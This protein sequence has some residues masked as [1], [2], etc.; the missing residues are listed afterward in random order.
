MSGPAGCLP[1]IQI[2]PT[3]QCNLRCLHCYSD[4]GPEVSAELDAELV[5]RVLSDAA[6]LGYRVCSVS[7]GEPLLYEPLAKVLRGAHEHGLITTVTTNGMLLDGRRL[8][9][10]EPDT[11]LVA[12]SLDG[13]PES[14]AEMRVSPSAFRTM[15]TRLSGLRASGIPFGFIFT[16]TFHNVNELD[17]VAQFAIEQG[18]KLLQIHPLEPVGRAATTLDGS[19]PDPQESGCALI[20]AVRLRDLYGDQIQIQFDL[21]TLPAVRDHPEKIYACP[22]ELCGDYTI[23]DVIAP[24][25]LETSGVVAPLQYGFPRPWCFGNVNQAPLRDLAVAWIGSK[26]AAFGA[27]CRDVRD[28]MLRH[29]ESPVVNWYVQVH[30]A[31]ALVGPGAFS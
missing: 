10:L 5:L 2:H 14:H 28:E 9:M 15:A 16:L 6:E 20:E 23:A 21:A 12:I 13:V 11:D 29:P 1:A 27:L 4:S 3:R 22:D 31:A 17:W 30:Q 19:L 25:V 24:I 18:A 7:G 8:G 26:F